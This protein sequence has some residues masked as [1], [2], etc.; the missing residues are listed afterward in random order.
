MA[1]IDDP[2]RGPTGI[3]LK[4]ERERRGLSAQKA[5]DEMHLDRWVIDALEADDY[6][7]IGPTVYAKGH[8][9]KYA[10]IAGPAGIRNPGRIR[11]AQPRGARPIHS[12]GRSQHAIEHARP[13]R[14]SPGSTLVLQVG[15][16]CCRR[17]AAGRGSVVAAL[18]SA[19][20]GSRHC[21]DC[22]IGAAAISSSLLRRRRKPPQCRHRRERRS[23]RR[24]RRRP[25]QSPPPSAAESSAAAGAAAAAATARR[26]CRGA[27]RRP[28]AIALE[29]F[30]R[31]LG[32]CA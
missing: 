20:Q 25:H 8:L 22:G 5:A 3:Q 32:G 4:A 16:H 14:R 17:G 2:A 9:K 1:L 6:Q 28:C 29:L 19:R 15:A 7:R 31:F 18:A 23:P 13:I 27:G 12:G 10:A 11:I 21:A 30:G 26:R 24:S